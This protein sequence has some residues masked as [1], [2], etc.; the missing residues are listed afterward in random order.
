MIVPHLRRILTQRGAALGIR[1]RRLFLRQATTSP[2]GVALQIV[3]TGLLLRGV[4]LVYPPAAYLLAGVALV[5]IGER[6]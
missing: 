6:L 4:Y 3:G 1:V 2:F 5:V